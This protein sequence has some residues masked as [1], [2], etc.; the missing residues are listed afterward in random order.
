MQ[1]IQALFILLM[2]ILFITI[3]IDSIDNLWFKITGKS[4]IYDIEY[5]DWD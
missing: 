3:C 1:F 5:E 4:F 2:L